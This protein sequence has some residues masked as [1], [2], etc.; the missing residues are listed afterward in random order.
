MLV[1]VV[2]L[3]TADHDYRYGARS[4]DMKSRGSYALNLEGFQI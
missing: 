3:I 2:V 1:V 4:K